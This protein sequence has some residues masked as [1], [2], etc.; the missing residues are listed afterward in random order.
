MLREALRHMVSHP[1]KEKVWFTRPSAIY[2]HLRRVT[3]EQISA[4]LAV[5]IADD[6]RIAHRRRMQRH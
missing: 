4:R 5:T 3:R 1:A 2:D 6:L